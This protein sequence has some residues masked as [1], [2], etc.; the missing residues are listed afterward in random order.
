M[1]DTSSRQVD[2]RLA[3]QEEEFAFL[4][5][6]DD[7]REDWIVRFEK[8]PD[9]QAREWAEHM[10][11]TYNQRLLSDEDEFFRLTARAPELRPAAG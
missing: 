8:A 4:V 5:V 7:D 2:G 9:F 1:S 11:R 10:V 3:V 6:L